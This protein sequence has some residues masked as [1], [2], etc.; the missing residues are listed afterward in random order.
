MDAFPKIGC[1]LLILIQNVRALEIL[2]IIA[3]NFS[4]SLWYKNLTPLLQKIWLNINFGTASLTLP[5]VG[6]LFDP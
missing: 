4:F 1:R 5:L 3:Q 6:P 2:V